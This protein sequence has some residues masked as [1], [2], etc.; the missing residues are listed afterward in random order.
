MPIYLVWLPLKDILAVTSL[1]IILIFQ[2]SNITITKRNTFVKDYHFELYSK[3][4]K[5]NRRT[6]AT[7][8]VSGSAG[9]G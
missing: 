8:I 9:V 7:P 5:T 3:S 6:A 1:P 2:H 4:S